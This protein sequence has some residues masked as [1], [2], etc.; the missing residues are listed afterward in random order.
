MAFWRMINVELWL[1]EFFDEP[2]PAPEIKQ[3]D[4]VANHGKQLDIEA[5]GKNYRRYPIR[6]EMINAET[7]LDSFVLD[8]VK[9]FYAQLPQQTPEHQQA[10]QGKSALFISEKVVAITQGRS[11]FIWDI[12]TGFWA[13][14]LSRFVTRTPTGIGL[15]SP[16]TMQLA[17]EEA[18]LPRILYASIGSA[19]GK[20]VGKRGLFYTLAGNNVGAID[21]PTE[22]SVYPANVS[23]KLAP[24]DPDQVAARL[25]AQVR[26]A[27]P[28]AYRDQFAG[29]VV[30]DANDIGR[31]VLGT[32]APD[33]PRL[34]ESI[35]ADNPLGQAQEQTPIA[36][37][38]EQN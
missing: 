7:D 16:F 26:A 30:I 19:L 24:K 14:L 11:Y 38:F 6:T 29:V 23:A 17:I 1:R 34:Y 12:K 13:N 36:L 32:D 20:L 35:F 31:N 22:Y 4:F 28:S 15:G 21:G 33:D 27:L 9:S 2:K 3:S 37:V 8:Y 5:N 10:T 18:G 25:S